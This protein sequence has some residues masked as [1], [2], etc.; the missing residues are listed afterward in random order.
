MPAQ[1]H[2]KLGVISFVLSLCGL[3][4][5]GLTY[6]SQF[7][8]FHKEEL[9]CLPFLAFI[10]GLISLFIPQTKRTYGIL[11][12]VISCITELALIESVFRAV[13]SM[14]NG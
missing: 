3:F 11:A 14:P 2:S 13:L 1:K 4:T 10:M 8:F 6:N 7:S 9:S 12:A 5:V